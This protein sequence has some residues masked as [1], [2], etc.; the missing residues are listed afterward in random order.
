[1]LGALLRPAGS[2]QPGVVSPRVIDASPSEIE[3]ALE[4]LRSELRHGN[5]VFG[6]SRSD[7]ELLQGRHLAGQRYALAALDTFAT[8]FCGG[9]LFRGYCDERLAFGDH[10]FSGLEPDLV[11]LDDRFRADVPHT[12]GYFVLLGLLE[13]QRVDLVHCQ[14]R[15]ARG[16]ISHRTHV[17]PIEINRSV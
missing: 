17:V 10:P 1:M 16:Q 13:V 15:H 9:N 2:A 5:H 8:L 7:A 3:E 14:P 6:V 12:L 11:L 4:L